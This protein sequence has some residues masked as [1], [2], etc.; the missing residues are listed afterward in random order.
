MT[1]PGSGPPGPTSGEGSAR[2]TYSI[3]IPILDELETLPEL[4]RRL[5]DL[6]ALLDGPAEVVLVD[7]GSSDGSFDAMLALHGS[8][9]RFRVLR[10]SRNFGHQIAISAGLQHAVGEAVVVMDGDLQD[11][12]EAV[13]ALAQAWRDGYHVVYAVR[14]QRQGETRM[15]LVSAHWFYR[16]LGRMSDVHVPS[17][18]GDFRLVDR[19]VVD[20]VN[21]MPEHRR[22]LRGLY[23]WVGFD[24]TGVTYV[25]EPR[26]AGRTKFP[27]RKMLGFAA[28]GIVSFSTVPLRMAMS[29]GFVVATLAFLTAVYGVASKVLGHVVPGWTSLVVIV[30]LL[31][32]VQLMVLGIMGEYLARIYD[33]AKGRPLYILRDQ[34]GFG[35]RP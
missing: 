30:G 19:R 5:V 34:V 26:H 3:V 31:S 8:D 10:L 15:K 9:P 1:T 14:E 12:P 25:R 21:A 6:M 11:P 35:R 20:A 2:P 7:D 23:A 4:G 29:L 18:A 17:D 33:E 27:L 28:D 13:L 22:Y 24:Q 16:L 32:G